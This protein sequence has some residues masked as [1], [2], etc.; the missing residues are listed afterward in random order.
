MLLSLVAPDALLVFLLK[1][2]SMQS[3]CIDLAL[4]LL[5]FYEP[6]VFFDVDFYYSP[7]PHLLVP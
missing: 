4:F 6:F 7:H 2:G 5:H 3:P 1:Y